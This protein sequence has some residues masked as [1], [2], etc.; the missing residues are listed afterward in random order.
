[1]IILSIISL[2]SVKSLYATEMVILFGIEKDSHA[3]N[4]EYIPIEEPIELKPEKESRKI[5]FAQSAKDFVPRNN[6]LVEKVTSFQETMESLKTIQA[7]ENLEKKP[8]R[9]FSSFR[10]NSCCQ[11]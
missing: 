9:N 7:N 4:Y 3:E 8:L 5:K 11:G 6:E 2:F 1:M 10:I